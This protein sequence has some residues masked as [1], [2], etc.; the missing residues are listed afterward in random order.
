MTGTAKEALAELRAIHCNVQTR[1]TLER[2]LKEAGFTIE[3]LWLRNDFARTSSAFH[4]LLDAGVAIAP[5]AYEV[6]FPGLAHDDGGPPRRHAR[7]HG[8]AGAGV[9]ATGAGLVITIMLE[10]LSPVSGKGS[11]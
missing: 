8:V 1:A 9:A 11:G 3:R 6:M 2:A 4:A 5:G 10:T 7:H